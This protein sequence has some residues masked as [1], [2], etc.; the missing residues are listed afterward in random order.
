M[1]TQR[2]DPIDLNSKEK[3]IDWKKE[4]LHYLKKSEKKFC[5]G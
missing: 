5:E 1:F 3:P 2:F 4:Q